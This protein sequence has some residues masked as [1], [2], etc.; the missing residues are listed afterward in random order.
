MYTAEQY[1]DLI[2]QSHKDEIARLLRDLHSINYFSLSFSGKQHIASTRLRDPILQ[3]LGQSNISQR[4]R[5]A[6]QFK[7]KV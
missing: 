1:P 5:D 2:P 4:Y 3:L 7:L 6:L